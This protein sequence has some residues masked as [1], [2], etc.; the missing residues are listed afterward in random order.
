MGVQRTA[1]HLDR[2]QDDELI[3]LEQTE[4]RGREDLGDEMESGHGSVVLMLL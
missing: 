1:H 4:S 3:P 2:N